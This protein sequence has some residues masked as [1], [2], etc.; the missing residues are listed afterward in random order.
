MTAVTVL[1]GGW[2]AEREV[3]LDSGK[4][5]ADA[6]KSLGYKVAAKDVKR[7]M[8]GLLKVL[9]PAPDVV[10]NA[11]HGRFG[12]DG[13]VQG[14]LDIMG[15]PYTHSGVC[16]SALA[17]DK[18]MAKRL[19]ATVGIP[20]PDGIVVHRDDVLNGHVMDP[21]YVV[22]PSGEGS[23]VGV[24]I[25]RKGDNAGPIDPK[26]WPFGDYVLVEKYIPGR[27]ITVAVMGDRALGALEIRPRQGFYDYDAKYVEGMADHLVPAPLPEE[28]YEEALRL[29]LLAHQTLGC[30]GVTRCDLRYDDT[31]GGSGKFYMLEINT[32][33]GMTSLSLV[34]E[35]A[36]AAGISFSDLVKW[37]VE[38]AICDG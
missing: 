11:L 15:I 22:K 36:A 25:V 20:C 14:M 9:T 34:P 29:S 19:F 4:A 18:P 1:M 31:Q 10:F 37:M 5:C 35:I 3:S 23:S 13:R 32:Q 7:D 27:E 28:D 2:S 12:E 38:E 16:A 17:M 30:R 8:K 21:P 33:P 6:L 26:S 24:H